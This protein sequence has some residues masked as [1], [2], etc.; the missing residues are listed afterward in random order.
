MQVELSQFSTL[1]RRRRAIL[2]FETAGY[3]AGSLHVRLS[4]LTEVRI[5]TDFSLPCAQHFARLLVRRA[6]PIVPTRLTPS[7]VCCSF[8]AG[9]LKF[10]HGI[11]EH[12][13]DVVD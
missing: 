5:I 13:L 6:V 3:N 2:L 1:T 10:A 11:I 4:I 7:T 9:I 12:M 8:I